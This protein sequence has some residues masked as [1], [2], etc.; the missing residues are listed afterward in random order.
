[1]KLHRTQKE[2]SH[3]E[4]RC[5][6]TPP[7]PHHH[8]RRHCICWNV[9]A[10][11]MVMCKYITQISVAWMRYYG[12][13]VQNY[14]NYVFFFL[15]LVRFRFGVSSLF[16]FLANG[17]P[18]A[19][20]QLGFLFIFMLKPH[21]VSLVS[22][23][24]LRRVGNFVGSSFR[25]KNDSNK[26]TQTQSHYSNAQCSHFKYTSEIEINSIRLVLLPLLVLLQYFES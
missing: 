4:N 20:R 21:N 23:V 26:C 25:K 24:L 10:H 13:L 16:I 19:C 2:H 9:Q 5:A 17:R 18:F 6:Q 11:G 12:G 7:S 3:S 15:H 1:M 8:H 22:T 14:A